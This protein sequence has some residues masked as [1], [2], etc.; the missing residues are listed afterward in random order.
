ME[1][2]DEEGVGVFSD[3]RQVEGQAEGGVLREVSAVGG[4][5][6]EVSVVGGVLQEDFEEDEGGVHMAGGGEVVEG[7][8][9]ATAVGEEGE[10][11]EEGE[12]K[13]L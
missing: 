13:V 4:V 1:G 7:E 12:G 5:L 8:A 9:V 11:E 10:V 6:Q 3:H 2:G